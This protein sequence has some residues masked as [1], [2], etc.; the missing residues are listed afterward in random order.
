MTHSNKTYISELKNKVASEVTLDGWLY[1]GRS[2]GKVLFLII[3]DGTGLC[4]CIVEKG[5]VPDD[6]STSLNRLGQESSL[7]RNRH[8]PGRAAKRRR[9]RTGRNRR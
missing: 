9:L 5:K 6:S 8:R 7:D 3:R 2:S 1:Q 4:Q